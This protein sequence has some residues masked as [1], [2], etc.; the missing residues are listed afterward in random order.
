[1]LTRMNLR[2]VAAVAAALMTGAAIATQ[3]SISGRVG[4]MIG[5]IRTG[6]LVNA[7]GGMIALLMIGFVSLTGSMA[8][9]DHEPLRVVALTAAAGLLGIFI[10]MGISFSVQ[11]VGVT[12][13]LAAVIMAQLVFGMVA[14]SL[15]AAGGAAIAPDLRRLAGVLAMGLGVWL[16]VPR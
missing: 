7:T 14:D 16:L 1:M 13:G 10:I 2:I 6:L 11:G 5:P 4:A 3:S 9:R 12:A 8:L 15:G